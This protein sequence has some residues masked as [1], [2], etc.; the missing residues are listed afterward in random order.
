VGRRR[1]VTIDVELGG[2]LIGAQEPDLSKRHQCRSNSRSLRYTVRSLTPSSR[3][4][5]RRFP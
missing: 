5:A 4:K 3:A 1:I 2:R